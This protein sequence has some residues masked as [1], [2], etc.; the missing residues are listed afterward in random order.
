MQR[1]GVAE[2]EVITLLTNPGYIVATP[3]Y[4]EP[5]YNAYG[6]LSMRPIRVSYRD[7][8]DGYLVITVT[9]L[10]VRRT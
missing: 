5:A 4:Q 10:G 6:S 7:Q 9:A 3:G 2:D 1:I 8:A